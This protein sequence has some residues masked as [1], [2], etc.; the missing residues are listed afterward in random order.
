M[1]DSYQQTEI[2]SRSHYDE[3]VW[4]RGT[5]GFKSTHT[6]PYPIMTRTVLIV[7]MLLALV[8]HR[9]AR[10][11]SWGEAE[12]ADRSVGYT[13]WRDSSWMGRRQEETREALRGGLQCGTLDL[14][15]PLT[16]KSKFTSLEKLIFLA[17][18]SS[19]F[20]WCACSVGI[21]QKLGGRVEWVLSKVAQEPSKLSV[22]GASNEEKQAVKRTLSDLDEPPKSPDATPSRSSTAAT[23]EVKRQKLT[24]EGFDV[25]LQGNST[26]VLPPYYLNSQ[27]P[28][29]QQLPSNITDAARA[30]GTVLKEYRPLD[31]LHE[32]V[33]NLSIPKH[34]TSTAASSARPFDKICS[35]I[36]KVAKKSA[37]SSYQILSDDFTN[38][39]TAS[40]NVPDGAEVCESPEDE[41]KM[42]LPP[43]PRVPEGQWF[44]GGCLRAMQDG[45]WGGKWAVQSRERGFQAQDEDSSS[46][47]SAKV[48]QSQTH[49][50]RN[51][52]SSPN[53]YVPL[54]ANLIRKFLGNATTFC[55]VDQITRNRD[56]MLSANRQPV[57]ETSTTLSDPPATPSS[58]LKSQ[59]DPGDGAEEVQNFVMRAAEL[60]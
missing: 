12:E 28:S 16:S 22:E 4:L 45:N 48:V 47:S 1:A 52:K 2:V 26:R 43:L 5:L 42:L 17:S 40:A 13:R 9:W 14:N 10:S 33:V 54:T 23:A 25:G 44:C 27:P 19:S 41:A 15:S 11:T 18:S 24:H 51:S 21:C 56:K 55:S 8:Q 49:V 31:I 38:E 32:R 30:N 36:A 35:K 59:F 34:G 53:K 46:T 50:N 60:S 57:R 7:F 58:L 37:T 3:R 29:K 20:S 6:A 39:Q